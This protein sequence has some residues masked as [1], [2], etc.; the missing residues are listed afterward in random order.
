[1]E[2]V[3]VGFGKKILK[4]FVGILDPQNGQIPEPEVMKKYFGRKKIVENFFLPGS[5]SSQSAPNRLGNRFW[6]VF[7]A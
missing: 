4:I 5:P 7:G 1:M 2:L 6:G 3:K